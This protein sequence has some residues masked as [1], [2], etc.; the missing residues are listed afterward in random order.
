MMQGLA[1][2][3]YAPLAKE[4][5]GPYVYSCSLLRGFTI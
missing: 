4:R 1:C 2:A 5:S 3:D